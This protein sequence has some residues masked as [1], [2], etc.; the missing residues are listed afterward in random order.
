MTGLV[1]E[2]D[3]AVA[4]AKDAKAFVVLLSDDKKAAH[5]KLAA[6]AKEH[7]LKIPLTVNAD[8]KKAPGAYQISDKVKHTILIYKGKKVVENFAADE[9]SEEKAKEI[10]GTAKKLF[11]G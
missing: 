4:D 2:I 10:A 6:L 3:K 1:K 8:G 9:V 11:Q 7:N 5:E